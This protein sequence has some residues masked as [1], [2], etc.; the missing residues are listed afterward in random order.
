MQ[1]RELFGG[2]ETLVAVTELFSDR[3]TKLLPGAVPGVFEKTPFFI[4]SLKCKNKNFY[5]YNDNKRKKRKEKKKGK[6][7][8]HKR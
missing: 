8:K 1:L 3:D 6:T 4:C 7:N 2:H 5:I